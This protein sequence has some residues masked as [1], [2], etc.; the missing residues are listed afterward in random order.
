M[1]NAVLLAVI[2]PITILCGCG[3]Q[4]SPPQNMAQ[5]KSVAERSESLE[6]ASKAYASRK[7]LDDC[8][9]Y[10]L[11]RAV[12][13]VVLILLT[14]KLPMTNIWSAWLM[15]DMMSTTPKYP[16]NIIGVQRP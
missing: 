15:Q 11:N 10:V 14:M 8:E 16:M 4:K 3:D 1:K 9:Q 13:Q 12:K 5:E 7:D 6:S 2:L